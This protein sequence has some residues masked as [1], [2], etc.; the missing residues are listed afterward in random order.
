MYSTADTTKGSDRLTVDNRVSNLMSVTL[1]VLDGKLVS[2]EKLCDQTYLHQCR[3]GCKEWKTTLDV[4]L[5]KS[6]FPKAI[7]HREYKIVGGTQG[8]DGILTAPEVTL[9]LGFDADNPTPTTPLPTSPSDSSVWKLSGASNSDPNRVG[10]RTSLSA[11]LTQGVA[12]APFKCTVVTVQSLV[13][14]FTIE[15][16]DLSNGNALVGDLPAGSYHALEASKSNAQPILVVKPQDGSSLTS[17]YCTL[18]NFK[19]EASMNEVNVV[20][21]KRV[22]DLA[23]CPTGDWEAIFPGSPGPPT[24]K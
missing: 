19:G 3:A 5:Q 9:P 20:K 11:T 8:A 10:V 24:L 2:E 15:G 1:S 7:V 4:A 17:Q 6:F 12:T 21:F 23:D 14:S 18:A 16:I 13:T 22:D